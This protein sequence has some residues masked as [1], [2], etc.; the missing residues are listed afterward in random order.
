MKKVVTI[1][2]VFV[3]LLSSVVSYAS[4]DYKTMIINDLKKR[5]IKVDEKIM[6]YI[7]TEDFIKHYEDDKEDAL[8]VLIDESNSSNMRWPVPGNSDYNI[9]VWCPNIRQYKTNWCSFA[10]ILQALYGI[11]VSYTVPGSTY[12]SKQISIKNYHVNHSSH[13]LPYVYE[14]KNLLNHYLSNAGYGRKYTYRLGSNIGSTNNFVSVVWYSLHRN[15]PPL[16]HAITDP[17]EYYHGNRYYHYLTVDRI[18]HNTSANYKKMRIVD[19]HYK[20][21][22]FGKHY[23][24]AYLVYKTIKYSGRYLIYKKM[25]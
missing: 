16:L 2:L 21:A 18:Y 25:N 11:G 3:L 19:S 7:A 12:N 15:R 23:E 10:N 6:G 14:V 4:L 1:L 9:S 8:K 17:L 24:D 13:S 5:N 20:N 22:Y